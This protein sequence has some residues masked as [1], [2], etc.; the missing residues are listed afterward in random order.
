MFPTNER[1]RPPRFPTNAR[2]R[3]PQ[4]PDGKPPRFR[5]VLYSAAARQADDL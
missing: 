3:P 4:K 5:E 2:K 1:E